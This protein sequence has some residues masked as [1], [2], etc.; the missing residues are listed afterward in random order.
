M[1]GSI[2]STSTQALV[3]RNWSMT[4]LTLF[5]YLLVLK[6]PEL[7]SLTR[8]STFL[9]TKVLSWILNFQLWRS[10]MLMKWLWTGLWDYFYPHMPASGCIRAVWLCSYTHTK[11]PP[12]SEYPIW[13][14]PRAF[15]TSANFV[16]VFK[17]DTLYNSF[18][19]PHSLVL[20]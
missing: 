20:N 18:K 19:A 4:I 1:T 3:S 10:S 8:A 12:R 2:I 6:A 5:L 7:D 9:T 14:I 17:F 13:T 11:S 15:F 16:V